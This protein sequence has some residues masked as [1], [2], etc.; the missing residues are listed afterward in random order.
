MIKNK[1]TALFVISAFTL[2]TFALP[3]FSALPVKIAANNSIVE[4]ESQN[5]EIIPAKLEKEMKAAIAK[6]YGTENTDTI[7]ANIVEIARNAK[8]NRPDNLIEQDKNRTSDWYK[9]EVIYMF[10]ADQ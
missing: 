2:N 7:Y 1:I 8:E 3:V 5:D 10:Y 6:I 9:D 4:N